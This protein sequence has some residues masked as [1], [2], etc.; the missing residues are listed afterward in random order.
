MKPISITNIMNTRYI[1]LALGAIF[2]ASISAKTVTPAEALARVNADAPSH[3]VAA[4]AKQNPRLVMTTNTQAGDPAVYLFENPSQGFMIVSADDIAYPLLGYSDKG[5]VDPDRMSP[6]MRWWLEEYGRQ[7]EWAKAHGNTDAATRKAPVDGRHDIAPL[8]KT[9]WDQGEP[10][11]QFCPVVS[12]QRGYTGCV[13]TSMAQIMNYFKYPEVGRGS[14]SYNDEG[15]GKRLSWNFADHPFDWD[16]MLD[17]YVSGK[18]T[19]EQAKTV[20]TLM[21]SAGASVKMQYSTDASAAL[22]VST[23]LALVKYF[24]YDPNL[25]FVLRSLVSSTQWDAM[26]YDN[27]AEVGPVLYGGGSM[28]GGGH[29][30]IVDGYQAETGLYHLNWGWSEMSDGYFSLEALN[31]TSLGAG[32]GGGGGYSF[33]QDGVFGIQ[34]P[35]GKPAEERP[36]KITQFGSLSGTVSGDVLTFALEDESDA[37]WVNYN[38]QDVTARFGVRVQNVDDAD[39]EGEVVPVSDK[40]VSVPVG[41]GVDPAVLKPSVDLAALGLE[42]GTY[43]F[44]FS[45]LITNLEDQSWQPVLFNY[46][47]SNYILVE[48]KGSRYTVTGTRAP[49]YSID[50]VEVVDKLY[51]GCLARIKY[52]ISN[53]HDIEI[54]RGIAPILYNGNAP[55]FMGESQFVSLKPGESY[56]GEMV[57][58]LYA[59]SNYATITEPTQLTLTFFEETSYRIMSD[60]YAKTVTYYPNPGTPSLTLDSFAIEGREANGKV[61]N[62]SDMHITAGL[63]LKSGVVAYPIYVVLTGEFDAAGQAEIID[64]FGRAAFMTNPGDK[65]DLDLHYN[66]KGAVPGQRYNLML[67]YALGAN[68]VP[69]ANP[70]TTPGV[71]ISFIA[72]DNAGI[73]GIAADT[74]KEVKWFTLQGLPVDIDRAPA[75]IYIR[76]RGN[77]SEKVT[78]R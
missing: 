32:G 31:P 53:P 15:C 44:T 65:F 67:C 8:L 9:A 37:S 42:D 12:G 27:L 78:K 29:S 59:M 23:E 13:A 38:P 61:E 7:I 76:V 16:N 55:M 14:I 3:K 1:A 64:Y 52:K 60:E 2:S 35:T 40:N 36:L 58:D 63:T 48:K 72:G 56:E 4:M 71:R 17:T 41:Y 11:N 43:K 33:T 54:A 68:I 49:F 19:E 62:T 30:F 22:S 39:S 10:Y 34:P 20:A 28:I 77:H 25:R 6:A 5:S 45:T 69:V 70:A 26:V 57:T 51:Y 66:F 50:K 18:Y 47:S 74:D 46:G 75:G 21:K 24:N 73:D